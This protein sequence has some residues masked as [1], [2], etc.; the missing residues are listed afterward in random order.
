MKV[1][2]YV[3]VSTDHQADDG[4]SIGEQTERLKAYCDARNWIIYKI[5][6]DAG[7]SG[8]KL[9]RPALQSMIRDVKANKIDLVLVYKLD[10]L[11]RSQKDT[12]YIIEDV[13]NPN[14]C[15]FISM[16][17][18]FD[19]TSPFG[20]AMIGI[21][22][23]F[24]QLEREQIK[25]R[26]TMGR[27]AR[28]KSGKYRGGANDPTGYE[29]KNGELTI[30]PYEAAQVKLIYDMFLK[31]F[32]INQIKNH[33]NKNY[34]NRYNHYSQISAIH[35]I[36]TNPIYCGKIVYR[37]EVYDGNHEPII[38]EETW[39][40]TQYLYNKRCYTDQRNFK[41]TT[42]LTGKLICKKCGARYHL[43]TRSD[44]YKGV[45]HVRRT[46][47][48]YSRSKTSKHMM[49]ADKCDS[50]IYREDQ[51]NKIVIDEIKKLKFDEKYLDEQMSHNQIN[52][53]DMSE[54]I[55]N[56]IE[57]VNEQMNKLMDL[58]TLG[59]IPMEM[60]AT[61]MSELNEKK[62]K[63]IHSLESIPTVEPK[64]TKKQVL[65]I[66]DA[67]DEVFDNGDLNEQRQFIDSLID[68]IEL[69][70]DDIYIHWNF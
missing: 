68:Y 51:L 37:D 24:A 58:Y 19:T 54:T 2:I 65:S 33:M 9:D 43:R 41:G 7:E 6:T 23:V 47:T 25:E 67:V 10:R 52:N 66:L 45:K 31:G 13:F 34:T 26:M 3:R 35:R 28:A 14:N 64:M 63:L 70:N 22:S 61:K 21:L 30:L 40:Q 50:K 48:C 42:I 27:M 5:Y 20:K 1:G 36:L 11:S 44:I 57:S 32:P 15:G 46:Y 16:N 49:K 8:T 69:D 62:N 59:T 39:Q 56:E 18:N 60:I 12:L 29:Y 17:E 4:Y 55:N 53:Y 38:D